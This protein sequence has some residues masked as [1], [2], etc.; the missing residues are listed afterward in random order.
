[1]QSDAFFPERVA[2]SGLSAFICVH[3]RLKFF[4]LPVPPGKIEP[5]IKAGRARFISLRQT[6]ERL[7]AATH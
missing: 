4:P 3:L 6:T 5:Q 2:A 1:M 7:S